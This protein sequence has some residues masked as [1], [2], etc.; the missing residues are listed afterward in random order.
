VSGSAG[1][2]VAAFL[3]LV[4]LLG[5]IVVGAELVARAQVRAVVDTV[6]RQALAART[7]AD[8]RFARVESDVEGYALLGLLRSRFER[9]TVSGET[10]VV[11]GIPVDSFEAVAERPTPDARDVERLRVTVRADAA[12]AIA[13]QLD[14]AAGETVVRTARVTAP[15]RLAATVPVELPLLGEV[16]ADVEVSVLATDE[17]GLTVEPVRAELPGLGLDVDVDELDDL[18]VL[19]AYGIAPEDLP[20]GLRVVSVVLEA[21]GDRPVVVAELACD[22]GCSLR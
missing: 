14:P 18:G 6:A 3:V 5:G 8:G 1:R 13:A 2:S 9:I 21:D 19:P 22:A 10:G 20:G 11:A 15:D 4:V 16:D 7:D 12:R 17:G